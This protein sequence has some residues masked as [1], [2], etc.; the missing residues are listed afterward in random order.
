MNMGSPRGRKPLTTQ[1]D[2]VENVIEEIMNEELIAVQFRKLMFFVFDGMVSQKKYKKMLK[3]GKVRRAVS[4]KGTYNYPKDGT[5]L[6]W[7]P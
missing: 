5:H 1:L 3:K 6:N 7:N 2:I 4:W